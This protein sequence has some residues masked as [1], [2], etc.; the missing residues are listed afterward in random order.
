[1]K[2]PLEISVKESVEELNRLKNSQTSLAKEKR[3]TALIRI[4]KEQDATRQDLSN[5]LG[6]DRKTL[7]IWLKEYKVGGIDNLLEVRSKHKG[8][9][10]ITEEIHNGLKARVMDSHNCFRGY[11]D[12]QRWVEEKFGVDA[13]YHL[14]RRYLIQH[15]GTKVKKPRKSHIKKDPR[16][17]ALFKN[18]T[19]AV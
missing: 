19:R 10:I 2:T 13:N 4:V 6:V 14:I 3:V 11:W 17:V 15:F 18:A 1:M 16:A 9:V 8:S 12:A 5:Y 7:R